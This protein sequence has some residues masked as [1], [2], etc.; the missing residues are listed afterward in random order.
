MAEAESPEPTDAQLVAAA[1]R[2]EVRAFD[3]LLRRYEHKVMRVLRLLGVPAQEREDVAQE[4]FLR[5]FR[6]LEGFRTDRSFGG[7]IY[8]V[9]VNATRDFQDRAAR[10][11]RDEA[12]WSDD[13]PERAGVDTRTEEGSGERDLA[14][15]LEDALASLTERERA[16]FVLLELEGL[17]VADVAQALGITR[18]TVRRHLGLART[19][20]RAVLARGS[21][22]ENR[23]SS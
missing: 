12:P 16:V 14:L 5:V 18:I 23:R 4:V 3:V 7:W 19:R 2:G 6:H 9:A 20:L 13:L 22:Q 11:R 1:L 17:E 8:R 10:R 15:R 21:E